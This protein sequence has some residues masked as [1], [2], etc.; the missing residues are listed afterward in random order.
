MISTN[1]RDLVYCIRARGVLHGMDVIIAE[2]TVD[3]AKQ[4]VTEP[5]AGDFSNGNPVIGHGSCGEQ[6]Q[7]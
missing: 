6:C 7:L 2:G 3:N 1:Q 4:L 5:P